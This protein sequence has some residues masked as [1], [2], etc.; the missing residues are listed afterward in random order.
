MK[1]LSVRQPWAWLLVNR[2]KD[3]ENRTWS[4][5]HRG[6]LVIHAAKTLDRE[7]LRWVEG[8]FHDIELPRIYA[9]GGIV[10]VVNLDGIVRASPSPWFFGPVGL[11]MSGGYPVDFVPY[12]GQLG[13]FDIDMPFF[14]LKR[15]P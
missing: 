15:L 3:I 1:A 7:G 14:K 13:L 4:T 12:R 5:K 2:H 6:P 10:W 11:Q 9:V 8:T